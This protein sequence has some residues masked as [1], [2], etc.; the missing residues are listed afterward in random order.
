MLL[1]RRCCGRVAA[2][3]PARQPLRVLEA[4]A[5]VAQVT[6]VLREQLLLGRI[7]KIDAV[8]IGKVELEAA[9]AVGRAGLLAD[10]DFLLPR[11][12]RLPV[13]G[14]RRNDLAAGPE[15]RNDLVATV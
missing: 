2:E 6:L 5:A 10:Q 4:D 15:L 11:G 7:V 8:A 3:Q 14:V 1:G 12:D 13:D 9:E